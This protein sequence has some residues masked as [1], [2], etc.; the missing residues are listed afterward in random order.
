MMTDIL[1]FEINKVVQTAAITL[2]VLACFF[3]IRNYRAG[4]NIWTGVGFTLAIVCYLLAKP[5]YVSLFSIYSLLV[6]TGAMIVPLFFWL[7]SN[8]IF[9]DDFK[10]KPIIF[11]FFLLQTF[12]HYLSIYLFN[13]S[14]RLFDHA[15]LAF[16][17]LSQIISIGFLVAGLYVAVKTKQHDLIES[18][19]RFRNIFI[20]ITAAL[21]GVTL[22]VEVAIFGQESPLVLQIL[23]RGSILVLTAYFLL[24]NFD[25]RE[26]FFFRGFP[27]TKPTLPED[28]TLNKKFQLLLENEKIYQKEGLT[29]R[30]LAAQMNEQEYRIRRLINGQ[31]GFKNFNDFLNQ[32]RIAEA[33]RILS[34]PTQNRKTILEIAYAL[35]YQSI[36]PFNKAFKEKKGVTPTHYRKTSQNN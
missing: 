35:G 36:G 29:I 17:I 1:L 19:L 11:A 23:Q 32:Y 30:E 26:G 31:L 33:S 24:S 2:L 13:T 28:P 21:I 27:K 3:L 15:L 16:H 12:P 22:I 20:S 6:L 10:A 34:D 5:E 7:L 14:I 8:A 4:L 18:R 9:N 25:I